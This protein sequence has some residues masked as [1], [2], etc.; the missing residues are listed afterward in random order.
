MEN[1]VISKED[2]SRYHIVPAAEDKTLHWRQELSYAV[3]L[4]NAF[5]GKTSVTFTTTE[6]PKTVQ[7]TVWSMTEDY[8]QLKGGVTIPLNSIVDVHF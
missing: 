1:N 8:I 2:I 7:T 5:K 6:G 4:G 3:R